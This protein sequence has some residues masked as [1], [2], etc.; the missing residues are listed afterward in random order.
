MF[1]LLPRL[2]NRERSWAVWP[3]LRSSCLLLGGHWRTGRLGYLRFDVRLDRRLSLGTS[4]LVL[5]LNGKSTSGGSS[6]TTCSRQSQRGQNMVSSMCRLRGMR[7]VLSQRGQVVH[8]MGCNLNAGQ[9]GALSRPLRLGATDSVQGLQAL[10]RAVEDTDQVVGEPHQS[11]QRRRP[12]RTT[13][14]S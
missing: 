12:R 7:I 3:Q 1:G 9:S 6:D 14:S 11:S 4:A 10:P 2:P 13:S 5:I 8:A